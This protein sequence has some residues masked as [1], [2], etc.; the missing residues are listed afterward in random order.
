[1]LAADI[2]RDDGNEA[3]VMLLAVQI[4]ILDALGR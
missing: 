3:G 1:M 4:V 2:D